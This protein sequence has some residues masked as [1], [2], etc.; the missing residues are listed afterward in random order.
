VVDTGTW[1]LGRRPALDGLRGIAVLLVVAYH[2]L[3]LVGVLDFLPSAGTVGVSMFFTLSGFLITSLL[4]EELEDRGRIDFRAFYVRRAR[5]LLPALVVLVAASAIVTTFRPSFMPLG[6]GVAALLYYANWWT[7]GHPHASSAVGH[8]WS[9]SIEEQFYLAWPIAVA[10]L[11]RLGGR[12]AI[13]WTALAGAATSVALR[14]WHWLGPVAG[15]G[16]R[17]YAGT[18]TRAD[19][20]LIGCALAVMM[21]HIVL[22][23]ARPA[24]VVGGLALALTG[25]G[26]YA[27]G[28]Q[29][30]APLLAAVGTALVIFGAAQGAGFRPMEVPLLAWLGRRS[31]GLYLWHM[32][33]YVL[34]LPWHLPTPVT[35]AVFAGC[36]LTLTG[37][38]WRWVEEP[39]LVGRGDRLQLGGRLEVARPRSGREE[40]DRA[41]S[42]LGR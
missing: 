25:C 36:S 22:E 33:V 42:S 30:L 14:E 35:L 16:Q 7:I 37:L 18:D 6:S 10:G 29:V 4:L 38:S 13:L 20:I 15:R 23:R 27:W 9:L 26:M 2:G 1:R 34:I 24:A 3:V 17:I 28:H 5:R 40:R 21:R 8:T 32:F 41:S 39:L 31:Y 11:A 19:A 12:R